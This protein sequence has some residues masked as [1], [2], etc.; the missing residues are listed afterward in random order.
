MSPSD[1]PLS[2]P[3]S[4]D[5]MLDPSSDDVSL[6]VSLV[7]VLVAVAVSDVVVSDAVVAGA[8]VGLAVVGGVTAAEPFA[9][10]PAAEP[11]EVPTMPRGGA[12]D[13]RARGRRRRAHRDERPRLGGRQELGVRHAVRDR[14]ADGDGAGGVVRERGI[15]GGRADRQG[16]RDP[17]VGHR[18]DLRRCGEERAVVRHHAPERE[19]RGCGDPP[20]R[21]Q[22]TDHL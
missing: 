9:V 15:G 10:A 21:L 13:A 6:V 22:A 16:A 5:P 14:I 12:D 1:E 17:R 2:E 11:E 19:E 4:L 8:V 18:G 20:T 3:S 7:I